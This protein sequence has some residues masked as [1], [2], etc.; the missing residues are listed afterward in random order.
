ML[1]VVDFDGVIVDSRYET[2]LI[3][4]QLVYGALELPPQHEALWLK[5]RGLA[6]DG[7]HFITLHKAVEAHL[8]NP[9][10]PLPDLFDQ[11]TKESHPQE[12][13]RFEQDFF[14]L[15]E[16]VMAQELPEWLHLHQLTPYGEF[17]HNKKL[18]RHHILTT[19]NR[20]A[21]QA[22]LAHFSIEIPSIYSWSD[23]K[24][25]GSKG[26]LLHKLLDQWHTN[27]AYVDD[28]AEQLD[29]VQ[30][31]RITCYFADWGYGKNTHYPIYSPA[32]WET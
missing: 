27:A 30:D 23:V 22:L 13:R 29:T 19:K 15:R 28:S 4:R 3:S 32:L 10:L 5:Y 21:V 6:V 8:A 2:Y 24:A 1:L 17:L 9:S 7:R 18:P 20:P 12:L 25:A 11:L 31:P 26:K 14:K 16:Q